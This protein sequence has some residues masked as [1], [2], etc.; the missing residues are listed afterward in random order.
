MFRTQEEQLVDRRETAGPRGEERKEKKVN[1]NA[2]D[3]ISQ[4]DVGTEAYKS[5][6]SEQL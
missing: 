2:E 3:T 1:M 6:K 5:S 4:T